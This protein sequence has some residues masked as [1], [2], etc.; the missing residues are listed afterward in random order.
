MQSNVTTS[1]PSWF[2]RIGKSV[3]ATLEVAGATADTAIAVADKVAAH[4]PQ[5]AE[6]VDEFAMTA[7]AGVKAISVGVRAGVSSTIGR[8]IGREEWMDPVKQD[9]ILE[10]ALMPSFEG[11]ESSKPA[12][13]KEQS[14]LYGWNPNWNVTFK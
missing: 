4:A 8:R 10:E 6:D 12:P 9:L 13:K 2:S 5:F 7:R 14:T 3:T 1:R 11:E